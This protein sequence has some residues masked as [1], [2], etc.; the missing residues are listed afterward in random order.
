[1]RAWRSALISLPRLPPALRHRNFALLWSGQTVSMLG[2]GI[3]NIA[4]PLQ[5]LQADRS[6]VSLSLVLIARVAPATCMLL[7]AGVVV[8]RIPRRLSMLGSDAAR[9]LAVAVIAV[10]VAAGGLRLWELI[11]MAAVFGVA[12][13]FFLPSKLAIVPE[14]LPGDLLVQGAAL[15]TGSQQVARM[16]AGPALGGLVIAVAGL[17]TAFAVDAASFA[18]SAAALLAVRGRP[19]P[20][21]SGRSVLAE[22]R[23]GLRYC[24]SQRWLWITIAAVGVANLVAYGPLPL[25]VP[26]LVKNV[27]RGGPVAFGL[28]TASAGVGGVIASIIAGRLGA[29]RRPMTVIWSGWGLAGMAVAGLGLAPAAWAAGLLVAFAWA[30]IMYGTVLWNSLMQARV[31]AALLGRASSV[32]WLLSYAGTPVGILAAGAA[33]GAA[34]P[35]AALVAGGCLAALMALVLLI[36]G[37]R[38]PAGHQERPL[39]PAPDARA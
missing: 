26:L 19:R 4:L 38:E 27:L 16:L 36:P 10:G 22:A 5:A 2:D 33:A 32:E 29:P 1:M 30:M 39:A 24:M 3:F 12:D 28:V 23:E 17:G 11:A 20:A 18:V 6:P 15:T 21:R 34:G 25:L 9:G 7:V 8:D 37:V 13:A 35:R 14:L 31:P